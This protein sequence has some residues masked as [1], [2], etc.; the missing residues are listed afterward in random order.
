[1]SSP[2]APFR[3]FAACRDGAAAVEFAFVGPIFIL[4][5][6]GIMAYGGYF[7][8]AHAVQQVA[9]DAARAAVAGLA[10]PERENLARAAVEAEIADYAYLDAPNASV[11]VTDLADRMTVTVTYDATDSFFFALRHIVPMPSPR[12]S[13]RASVRH[14]GY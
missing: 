3:K 6:C 11:A 4:M 7:W 14:G 1:M 10:G 13:R 2:A 12:I 9:N 8:S 5:L